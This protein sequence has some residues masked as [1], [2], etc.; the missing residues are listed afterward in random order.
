MRVGGQIQRDQSLR[1]NV[2]NSPVRGEHNHRIP[3]K[4]VLLIFGEAATI[5]QNLADV[6]PKGGPFFGAIIA[7]IGH[8]VK[9]KNQ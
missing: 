6:Y 4:S 1:I 2:L 9:R 5:L 3:F 8:Q 7:R